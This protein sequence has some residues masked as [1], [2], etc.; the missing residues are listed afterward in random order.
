MFIDLCSMFPNFIAIN[1]DLSNI[2]W[3]EPQIPL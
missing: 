2:F 3:L 1:A